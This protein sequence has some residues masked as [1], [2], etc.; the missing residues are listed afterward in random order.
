[1]TNKTP[2]GKQKH[3]E[4]TEQERSKMAKMFSFFF[5]WASSILRELF[6]AVYA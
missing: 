4:I 5:R 2:I 3:H 1:M 6:V